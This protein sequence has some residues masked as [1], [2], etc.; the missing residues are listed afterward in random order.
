MSWSVNVA[1]KSREAAIKFVEDTQKL[2][3]AY[4]PR[5]ASDGV[6][7]LIESVGTLGEG[8]GIEV[9]AHGHADPLYGTA[10]AE[11]RVVDLVG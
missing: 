3:A 1:A 10:K 9:S 11:V 5:E 7:A 2:G 6:I 8:K 4:F